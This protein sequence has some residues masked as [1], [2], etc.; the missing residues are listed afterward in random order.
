MPMKTFFN[1]FFFLF[2]LMPLFSQNAH[3][4]VSL[5]EKV[6]GK[7]LEL[8]AVNSNSI[9][10]DV[11]LRVET[12]DYRRSSARP[13]IKTIP[14]NSEV[15]LITMVKL[16]GK[17]GT[18]STTF[19]VNEISKELSIRKD[20]EDFEIK[21]D[22]AL[23]QKHLIIYTKDACDLCADARQLLRQNKIEYTE[24]SIDKDSINLMK[25]IKE[26]K[27]NNQKEKALAP[28]I[29]IEDS[30]YTNLRT[31]QDLINALKNHL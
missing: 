12:E 27:V 17:E 8:F 30:L 28:I 5:A 19:V 6:K 29:K 16:N 18:Y 13:I 24:Y 10:Y 2:F 23:H 11:F 26:F 15:R 25:L 14:P 4:Y 7:R 1:T 9:S 21:F 31:K 3:P 22:D 20:H